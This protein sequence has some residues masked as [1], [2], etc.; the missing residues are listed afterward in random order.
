YKRERHEDL[1][2]PSLGI[3]CPF[4]RGCKIDPAQITG[5]MIAG[6]GSRIA[7]HKKTP[8]PEDSGVFSA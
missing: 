8:E 1:F 6:V 2:A 5:S 3:T 4:S 7:C